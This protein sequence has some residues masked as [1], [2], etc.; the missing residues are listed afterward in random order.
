[1]SAHLDDLSLSINDYLQFE[2]VSTVRHEYVSG[3]IFA[4]VGATNAHNIIVSN[5]HGNIF[6][7]VKTAG[8][9]TYISDMKIKVESLQNFYY[10]DLMISCERAE[11][12]A[13]YL[14]APSLIVEVLSPS[15]MDIDRREKLIAY[16]HIPR[17][18]DYVIIYQDKMRVEA[19]R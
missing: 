16:R 15:T 2:A 7:T 14:L 5:L 9:Q 6:N 3:R 11:P 12:K 17:L 13:V 19:N 10:P 4:M 1:M 18:S 8:C